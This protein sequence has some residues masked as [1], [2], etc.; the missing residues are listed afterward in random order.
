MRQQLRLDG[1][2]RLSLWQAQLLLLKL[3][4]D[5]L[6]PRVNIHMVITHM[7]RTSSIC[8]EFSSTWPPSSMLVWA[9]AAPT[10]AALCSAVPTAKA[11]MST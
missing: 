3:C 4:K 7:V 11:G 10:K 5:F 6:R 2:R 1:R 8:F 9:D